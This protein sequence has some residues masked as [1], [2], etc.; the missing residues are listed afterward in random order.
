MWLR[1]TLQYNIWLQGQ[2]ATCICVWTLG[3]AFLPCKQQCLGK[4]FFQTFIG[5]RDLLSCS[6]NWGWW[7]MSSDKT[8]LTVAVS[9]HPKDD[10]WAWGQGLCA[11]QT[12]HSTLKWIKKKKTIFRKSGAHSCTLSTSKWPALSA[13]YFI[14]GEGVTCC[15]ESFSSSEQERWE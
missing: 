1:T 12:S 5:C 4:S 14:Q 8:W 10:E 11:G 9:V 13:K 2:Y 6:H 7:L 15:Y 3:L